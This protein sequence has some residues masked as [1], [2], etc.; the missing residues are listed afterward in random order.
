MLLTELQAPKVEALAHKASKKA[1]RNRD[2]LS[3]FLIRLFQANRSDL[4]E[5]RTG[6][7]NGKAFDDED[8]F[9]DVATRLDLNRGCVGDEVL[10]SLRRRTILI[11]NRVHADPEKYG[12][13]IKILNACQNLFSCASLD[14]QEKKSSKRLQ[15]WLEIDDILHCH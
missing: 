11:L 15:A 7:I 2:Y 6:I 13:R 9:Q 5:F 12:L 8:L 14:E 4:D 1:E 10:S 3:G